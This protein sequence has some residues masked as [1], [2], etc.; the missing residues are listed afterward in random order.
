ML[1]RSTVKDVIV[2]LMRSAAKP[3]HKKE[4]VTQVLSHRL[5]KENTI[6][7]NLQDSK[8]FDRK[9]DGVYALREA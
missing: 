7:L 3:L 4:I 1:F 6:L 5:V 9:G 8:T 2:D